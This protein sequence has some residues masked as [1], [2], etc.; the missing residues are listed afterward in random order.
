MS[1]N[2]EALRAQLADF[3]SWKN[4]HA[5]FDAVVKGVP[6]RARG[7]VPKGFAHS[8][9]QLVEH[10][11]IAQAD[12]LDFCVNPKYEHLM[13]WP[14]DYWPKA[15]PKSAAAWSKAIA[16]FRHDLKAMQQLA[17]DPGIDLFAKIPG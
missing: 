1:T 13:K 17:L 14:D 5:D 7:L 9:W 4:A 8:V 3:L 2:D 15:V 16:G 11:R 12:I 10:M 6:P